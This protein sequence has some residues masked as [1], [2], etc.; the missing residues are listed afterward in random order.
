MIVIIIKKK[1]NLKDKNEY[2]KESP[3]FLKENILNITKG[4]NNYDGDYDSDS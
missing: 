4:E 3:N 2:N 1:K